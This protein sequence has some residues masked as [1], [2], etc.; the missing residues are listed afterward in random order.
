MTTRSHSGR[1]FM[2]L[3]DFILLLALTALACSVPG[4]GTR[5]PAG[6][7]NTPYVAIPPIDTQLPA[8]V[9]TPSA[10]LAANT[11]SAPSAAVSLWENSFSD[12]NGWKNEPYWNSIQFADVNGDGKADVCGRGLAGVYCGVSNGAGFSA[13][14]LWEGTFSDANGWN[15]SP[16]WNTIKFA[17]VNGDGKDDVC[18]RGI[19]G[20]YCGISNG[21]GFSAVTLWEDNF[22]DGNGWNQEPYWNSIQFADV[23]GDGRADVCAR[24]I[25]GEYCGVS[26]GTA[27]SAA[28]VWEDNFSDGNGWN[29]SPY[30]NT[31]SFPDVNGDAKA[32][33]CGRGLAGEYCGISNG[34]VFSAVT[35]WETTFSDANG[36][37]KSPYWNTIAFPDVNGDGL[38]DL[39][40]RGILGEYCGISNGSSFSAVTQWD[41]SFSDANGWNKSPYWNTLQF[42]DVN[43]DGLA[44]LC[45]RGLAGVSCGSSTGSSFAAA[46]IWENIFS[47]AN[48]WNKSPYF[49]TVLFADLNGDNLQDVCGRGIEGVYCGVSN[50]SAFQAAQ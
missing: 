25:A 19:L 33:I 2:N 32:D 46:V 16:Y 45:G 40:G 10:P 9:D 30:W 6:P 26:S 11:P 29:K 43:G 28:T 17:D 13:V 31:I 21:A 44:D 49:N 50:G 1:M 15:K 34:Y 42:A 37:N 18:G 22:S 8:V 12:A 41:S 3:I 35:L 39:C 48:G 4:G 5:V 7:S 36:W 27:F 24:G 47:D 38:S 23:N 20:E 14:A